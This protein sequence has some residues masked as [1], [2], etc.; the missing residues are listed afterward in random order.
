[1]QLNQKI[2]E[3]ATAN[4]YLWDDQ[5][6]LKLFHP[7]IKQQDIER[8]AA[9]GRLIAEHTQLRVPWT[10]EII[11]HGDLQGILFERLHGPTL[12]EHLIRRPWRLGQIAKGFAQLQYDMHQWI[13]PAG[14]PNLHQRTER[15]IKGVE[16]LSGDLKGRLLDQLGT[17]PAQRQLCHGDLHPNNVILQD[18]DL[19]IIDWLDTAAGD[20][21]A[22]V[23][24][25]S[26]LLNGAIAT[27]AIG[28]PVL[29]RFAAWFHKRY[30]SHY[31]S[32]AS[33]QADSQLRYR[34]WIPIMAA[35]RLCEH[36]PREEAWLIEQA[37]AILS[38]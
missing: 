25:T 32:L 18:K 13:A 38:N 33:N 26:V 17:F 22:D 10:G 11:Q 14:I 30:I 2:A 28:G 20:P 23:A 4:I 36:I 37:S 24:R 29:S 34:Q 31:F 8:E 16:Q 9:H 21:L 5:T 27:H 35:A 12:L 15:R 19:F 3:G 1:M 7:R 6:I